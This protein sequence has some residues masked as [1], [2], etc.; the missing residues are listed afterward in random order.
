MRSLGTSAAFRVLAAGPE[1]VEDAPVDDLAMTSV[2]ARPITSGSIGQTRSAVS[3][4]RRLRVSTV[5][6]A[7][8]TG[9][10]VDTKTMIAR[11]PS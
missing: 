1:G 5:P 11:A 2:A 7:T 3:C 6:R 10:T 4:P 9:A 8:I